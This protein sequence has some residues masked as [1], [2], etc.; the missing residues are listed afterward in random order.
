MKIE[1]STR[2]PVTVLRLSGEIGEADVEAFRKHLSAADGGAR[3]VLDLS[4]LPHLSSYALALIGHH[5]AQLRE[6]GGR[7]ALA[8]VPPHGM[9]AIE[10]AGLERHLEIHPTVDEAVRALQA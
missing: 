4:G 2:G 8:A 10:L 7:L 5:H 6:A 9:R 1:S 3:Y